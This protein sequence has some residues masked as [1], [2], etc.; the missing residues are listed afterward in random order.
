MSVKRISN[1]QT[2]ICLIGILCL[3]SC[4]QVTVD[5]NPTAAIDP[6]P[7]LPVEPTLPMIK[8]I[9][10]PNTPKLHKEDPLNNRALAAVDRQAYDTAIDLFNTA[11][12]NSHSECHTKYNQA[13]IKASQKAKAW[14]TKTIESYT[15]HGLT[16]T[17]KVIAKDQK[18]VFDESF[19][20]N[21]KGYKCD[22]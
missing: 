9:A 6:T 20:N 3:S 1:Y 11:L 2:I 13:W 22:F 10:S 18:E 15:L 12:A 21:L 7:T 16:T 8:P 14:K 19:E 5:S 17:D 4:R